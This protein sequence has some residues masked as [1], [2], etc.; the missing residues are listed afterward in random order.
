MH[1]YHPSKRRLPTPTGSVLSK[2]SKI[3]FRVANL[4]S[5]AAVQQQLDEVDGDLGTWTRCLGS[6][7]GRGDSWETMLNGC[8]GV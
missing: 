2:V 1:V 5:E 6:C 7:R 4:G 3:V 8:E